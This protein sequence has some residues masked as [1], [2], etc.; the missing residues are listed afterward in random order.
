MFSDIEIRNAYSEIEKEWK[1]NL[2]KYDVRL[3][4]LVSGRKYT[5]N[6]LVL[7]YLY[8]KMGKTNREKSRIDRLKERMWWFM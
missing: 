4:R 6:A 7:I 2:E 3:P 8:K 5:I 1:I